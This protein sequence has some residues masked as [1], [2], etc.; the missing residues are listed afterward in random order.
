[1]TPVLPPMQPHRWDVQPEEAIAIQHR[2]AE[3]VER[4]PR[5]ARC[6]IIA[7]VDMSTKDV[8]RAAV[9]LLSYPALETLEIAR[10]E[11]PLVFPYV[12]GLLS[13]R[14]GPAVLAAFGAQPHGPIC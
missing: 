10:A 9:V 12:P 5:P 2:L 4:A 13:F 8:A 14:E 7:G 11:K 1:M 3:R 6:A